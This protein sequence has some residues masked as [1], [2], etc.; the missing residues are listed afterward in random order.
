MPQN[1]SLHPR[2]F[3]Y[4]ATS[5]DKSSNLCKR[6]KHFHGIAEKP[7]MKSAMLFNLIVCSVIIWSPTG[8][9]KERDIHEV[10]VMQMI[11]N[12]IIDQED[13]DK[14]LRELKGNRQDS[15]HHQVRGVASKINEAKTY[16]FVN[17]PL[18]ISTK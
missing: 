9:A 5:S 17:P 16:E 8:M 6:I 14:Q 13:G 11:N 10:R 1:S 2:V 12:G 7:S 18:E 15:F 4:L 3:N